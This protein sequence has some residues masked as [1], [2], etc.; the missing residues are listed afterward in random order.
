M[1]P[2]INNKVECPARQPGALSWVA[3]EDAQ[4]EPRKTNVRVTGP[5]GRVRAS[6]LSHLTHGEP[7][8]PSNATAAS[9]PKAPRIIQRR[10]K[11]GSCD[12]REKERR[13]PESSG[14]DHGP[15]PRSRL[16]ADH[17]TPVSRLPVPFL[18][19]SH[20][21]RCEYERDILRR[22]FCEKRNDKECLAFI[23][24]LITSMDEIVSFVHR[25][26]CWAG[27]G[28]C[29]GALKGSFNIC[30]IVKHSSEDRAVIRFPPSGRIYASWRPK[31]L[32]TR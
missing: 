24:K 10:R 2:V 19:P 5:A 20:Q 14:K 26:L 16:P 27:G 17:L 7:S 28:M 29:G 6:T 11:D 31:R 23:R 18:L 12:R 9:T 8:D 13:T 21:L 15:E 1:S 4:D 3:A 30:V 32:G 25:C 22:H